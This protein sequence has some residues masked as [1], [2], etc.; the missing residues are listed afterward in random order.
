[1]AEI[2]TDSKLASDEYKYGFVSD[3]DM[4]RAP[5]GLNEDIIRFISSKK[6]EPE[7]MLEWRMKAYKWWLAKDE[8]RW[9]LLDYP[10]ID[11]QDIRYYAAPKKMSDRF[12]GEDGELDPEVKRA[13]DKLGI[14]VEEQDALTG[15]AVDAVFD[16]VSVATTH[17]KV[18]ASFSARSRRRCGITRNWSRSTLARLFPTPTTFLLP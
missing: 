12:K 18:L 8:P 9:A 7:W 4:D 6:G 11:Y 2:D 16:S 17:R 15:V 1:M 3:V 5:K 10:E 14:P 13:F